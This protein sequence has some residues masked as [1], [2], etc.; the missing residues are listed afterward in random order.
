VRRYTLSAAD[1][2][3]HAPEHPERTAKCSARA[4]GGDVLNFDVTFQVWPSRAAML[5]TIQM[6][7]RREPHP[8]DWRACQ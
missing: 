4:S 6:Q 1:A 7:G 3:T 5:K 8:G 2:D